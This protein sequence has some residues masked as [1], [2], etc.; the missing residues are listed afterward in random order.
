VIWAIVLGCLAAAGVVVLVV[1]AIGTRN[2]IDDVLVEMRM[3]EERRDELKELTA[4]VQLPH[5]HHE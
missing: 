5:R 1:M 2:K 3:L 4:G